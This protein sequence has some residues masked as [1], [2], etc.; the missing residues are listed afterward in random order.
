M[1]DRFFVITIFK[2]FLYICSSDPSSGNEMGNQH[3]DKPDI[4]GNRFVS[5]KSKMITNK[6]QCT[7]CKITFDKKYNLFRHERNTCN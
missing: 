6:H 4:E 1:F 7:K 5:F 3:E 2:L